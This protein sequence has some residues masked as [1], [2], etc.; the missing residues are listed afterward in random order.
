[1]HTLHSVLF[2]M[3]LFSTIFAIFFILVFVAVFILIV[4][5]FYRDLFNKNVGKYRKEEDTLQAVPI[6]EKDPWNVAWSVL[7][8][9][10][11]IIY[12]TKLIDGIL[13][14]ALLLPLILVYLFISRFRQAKKV[15][16]IIF[17]DI[18]KNPRQNMGLFLLF[19]FSIIIL[20]L[21]LALLLVSA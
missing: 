7:V 8:M 3:S 1:M 13:F 18:F 15:R 20:V 17:F 14:A 10:V 5:F 6:R 12:V 19:C 4:M 11:L 2:E 21:F 16:R 9:L